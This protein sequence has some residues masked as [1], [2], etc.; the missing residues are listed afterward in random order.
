[1]KIKTALISVYSKEG[2][3]EFAKQLTEL[4]ITIL[5]TGG[6]A[7]LLEKN[8]IPVIKIEDYT[9]LPEILDGRVKT[10]SYKIFGG[11]LAIRESS[12]HI[13]E[14][15]KM[16][17]KTID[18]VVVNLYPFEEM[19]K[20]R[21][22]IDEM[23][24]YIDIG[25]NTLLR[26]A[27]K[28]FKYVLP[29]YDKKY[30]SEIIKQLK[31]NNGKISDDLRI[32]LA[33]ET[34][35]FTSHY[36]SLISKFLSKVSGEKDFP[37][38]Y[39]LALAKIQDL[40]YGENPHQSAGY[41]KL[42]NSDGLK[43]TQLWGK[44]LSFNNIFDFYASAN[45]VAELKKHFSKEICVIIKHRNP[46]GAALGNSVKDAYKKALAGDPISAFGGIVCFSGT[47][48]ETT[49]KLITERFYEII[50]AKNFEK[51]A[52]NILKTKKNLRIIK[53]SSFNSFLKKTLMFSSVGNTILVQEKDTELWKDINSV[54]TKKPTKR[55][56]EELKFAW[57]ICKYVKSNAIV[58]TKNFQLIGAGYGQ[59]SRIDAAK[60]GALKAKQFGFDLKGAYL[61]SDAFFPFAD[62][63]K[64]ADKYKI[65]AIIQPGGSI[66][67][68][69]VIAE[70]DKRGMIMVLTAM[71]HFNH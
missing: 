44:E 37:Q 16:K 22:S 19:L 47:V 27:A 62:S 34:F 5:S 17:I 56:I 36:D 8:N 63:I 25:G 59:T 45:I 42:Y 11:I 46:C 52:L 20:K 18:I 28:N 70:A 31:E 60:F 15:E 64:F 12:K 35:F 14:L 26:A 41:Y 9:G 50:V 23:I 10:L 29:V 40:R 43:F 69:E 49:A 6:T 54:T 66:R 7:R 68:K 61:A 30:Y 39:N 2:I 13:R 3:T 24:E 57:I 48:D 21:L 65:R 55:D 71:R 67:D 32:K 38:Y 33:K 51:K 4:G 1:M 58:Y 53:I